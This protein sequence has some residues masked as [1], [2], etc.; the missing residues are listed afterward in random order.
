MWLYVCNGETAFYN[1][2]CGEQG[3]VDKFI[4]DNNE[5]AVK[6]LRVPGDLLV[7]HKFL[8]D[9]FNGWED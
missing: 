8:N 1:F 9:Y 6:K 4:A 3:E 5:R 2:C 7:A